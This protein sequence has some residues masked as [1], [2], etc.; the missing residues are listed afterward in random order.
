MA[1]RNMRVWSYIDEVARAGSVRQ[2]SQRL[3]VTPS[4]VLRRIQ[5]V[6]YDLGAA[7]F[8]RDNSGMRLTSAGEVLIRWIRSQSADLQ[9]VHSYIQELSGLQRGE[10]RIACSQALTRGWL[11]KEILEFRKAHQNVDFH[12]KV[13][14]HH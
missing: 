6:E 11:L 1:L 8:E 4:A 5:D 13:G 7:I 9:R 3:N 14:N 10:I 2:A 12:V